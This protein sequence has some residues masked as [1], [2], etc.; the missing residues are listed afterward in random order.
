MANTK[1]Q[2]LFLKQEPVS[3]LKQVE[4]QRLQALTLAELETPHACAALLEGAAALF[5]IADLR[6]QH[7]DNETA[8]RFPNLPTKQ[9]PS[10]EAQSKEMRAL[11]ALTLAELEAISKLCHPQATAKVISKKEITI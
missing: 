5:A 2:N 8:L 7:N 9:K 4:I 10:S 11:L 3:E 1:K 6:L